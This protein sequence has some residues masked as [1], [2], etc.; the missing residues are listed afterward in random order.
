MEV[1]EQRV[2]SCE[3]MHRVLVAIAWQPVEASWAKQN[4]Q[5]KHTSQAVKP[6]EKDRA[7]SEHLGGAPLVP[8]SISPLGQAGTHQL[9]PRKT[10]TTRKDIDGSGAVSAHKC[11]RRD[12]WTG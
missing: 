7:K 5:S 3:W 8:C 9:K 11:A 1:V 10:D 6:R 2:A 12:A 4:K